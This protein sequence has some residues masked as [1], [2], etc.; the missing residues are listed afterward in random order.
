MKSIILFISC[1]VILMLIGCQSQ[2]RIPPTIVSPEGV[3]SLS[4]NDILAISQQACIENDNRAIIPPDYHHLNRRL[5]KIAQSLPKRI[6]NIELNYKVYIDTDP[7][8]W[9]TANG[10]IRINSGLIKLLEDN[11]LQAVLAHEQAHIAL[12]HGISLFRQAPYIEITDK[13]NE[14]VII[15]K[16]ETSHQY[17][18]EA[19]SYAFNLLVRE[20][21]DPIGLLK[22]LTK[23][24]IHSKNQPTSH[25]SRIKRM[26]NIVDR[27]NYH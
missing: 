22:M 23:M 1:V 25:P 7:N 10:C 9:S 26:A 17:E 5:S 13:A 4:E 15:V 16:E 6:N 11:E 14:L 3:K 19:D 20:S 18:V 21:I 24:P 27:L 2:T 12:K 8:A